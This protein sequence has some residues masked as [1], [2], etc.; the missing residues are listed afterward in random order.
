MRHVNRHFQAPALERLPL[1]IRVSE[2]QALIALVTIN[3]IYAKNRPSEIIFQV[4]GIYAL[5]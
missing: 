1:I 2:D 4:G 5:P 3:G